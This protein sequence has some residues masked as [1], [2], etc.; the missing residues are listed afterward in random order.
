MSLVHTFVFRDESREP[1]GKF[2]YL[3]HI[4][5][6]EVP[7]WVCMAAPFQKAR[8]KKRFLSILASS[9]SPFLIDFFFVCMKS[10]SSS[11]AY[12]DNLHVSCGFVVP[13][14]E[15]KDPCKPRN[16]LIGTDDYGTSDRRVEPNFLIGWL[17][18]SVMDRLRLAFSGCV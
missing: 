11:R 10:L 1:S 8:L 5:S 9:S 18:E 12:H 3:A 7:E 4:P 15:P 14:S 17:L 6:R 13:H 16:F 2:K